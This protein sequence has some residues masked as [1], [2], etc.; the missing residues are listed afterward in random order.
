MALM[1]IISMRDFSK[2]DILCVLD[3][4]AEV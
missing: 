1:D 4:A 2:E 3:A